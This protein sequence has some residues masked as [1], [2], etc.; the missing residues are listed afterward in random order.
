MWIMYDAV[1]IGNIPQHAQCVAGY[2]GGHWVTYPTLRK[3][4]PNSHVLS[5][6]VNASEKA[7]CLDVETG[8]ATPAEAPHWVHQAHLDGIDRPVVYG[9]RDQYGDEIIPALRHN[10]IRRGNYRIWTAHYTDIP[11]ICGPHTCGWEFHADGTQWTSR[12]HGLDLDESLLHS[13]FFPPL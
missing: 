6:A 8:D 13:D 3:M 9:S 5:I 1:N 7:H 12:A 4:F 2:V 10:F 11:H